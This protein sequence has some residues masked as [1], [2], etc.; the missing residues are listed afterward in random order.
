MLPL[1][2]KCDDYWAQ[3]ART[4]GTAVASGDCV[5]EKFGLLRDGVGDHK[6]TWDPLVFDDD[7]CL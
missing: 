1:A 7:P 6:E 5:A 4:V 3:M 2:G